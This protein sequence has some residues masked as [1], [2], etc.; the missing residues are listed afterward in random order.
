MVALRIVCAVSRRKRS[1]FP[2]SKYMWCDEAFDYHVSS[3]LGPSF[4][5]CT[6]AAFGENDTRIVGQEILT[7][8]I[9]MELAFDAG[10][11]VGIAWFAPNNCT[12]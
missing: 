12:M 8:L 6:D 2:I 9:A 11:Q 7:S 1:H 10:G 5:D 3:A 4:D